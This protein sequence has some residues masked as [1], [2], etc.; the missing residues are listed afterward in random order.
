VAKPSERDLEYVRR[1]EK[2]SWKD[3]IALWEQIK[4]GRTPDW[5]EGKALEHLVVRAFRL[6]KLE[7]EYPYDVP[8]G[9]KAIEQID[10]LVHLNCY[11]FLLECK[12]KETVDITAI[13]KLRN[14]LLRR[15]DTTFG[16]VFTAGSFSDPA[17]ILA[18]FSVPHRILLWSAVDI[19]GCLHR[20]D[21]ASRLL[22]KYRH[23]CK[24]GMTDHSPNYKDLEE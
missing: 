18:E 8:P 15:P 16:C 2:L 5:H 21:F 4:A 22:E 7:A 12:D 24:Y 17:L 11:T 10:G 13:A 6:S 1:A 19:D 9:G 23:I 3:L 20:K 14:Q